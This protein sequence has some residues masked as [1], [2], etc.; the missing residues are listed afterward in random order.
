MKIEALKFDI[1]FFCTMVVL[2]E[3]AHL[4]IL[5]FL[6]S[7]IREMKCKNLAPSSYVEN[8]CQKQKKPIF[9]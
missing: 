6:K 1:A 8:K 5:V 9:I 2:A 4:P 3:R 7:P